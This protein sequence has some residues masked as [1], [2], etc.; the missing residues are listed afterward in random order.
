MGGDKTRLMIGKAAV[1][2][3]RAIGVKNDDDFMQVLDKGTIFTDIRT[4][5][6]RHQLEKYRIYSFWGNKDTVSLLQH[7]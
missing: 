6:W 1:Q 7:F 2:F 3:A 5:H 4:E